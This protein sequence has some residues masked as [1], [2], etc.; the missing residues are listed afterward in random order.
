MNVEINRHARIRYTRCYRAVDLKEKKNGFNERSGLGHRVHSFSDRGHC[1]RRRR[2]ACLE[3]ERKGKMGDMIK[4]TAIVLVATVDL[5]VA[6][7]LVAAIVVPVWSHA[8][9]GHR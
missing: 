1:R 6:A 2:A 5:A 9:R 7:S 8:R 4:E 3:T